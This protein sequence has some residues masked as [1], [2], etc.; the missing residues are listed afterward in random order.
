M[1]VYSL[2]VIMGNSPSSYE[3]KIQGKQKKIYK[4]PVGCVSSL[5]FAA[6]FQAP[7]DLF[8][9]LE[10][11]GMFDGIDQ[12]CIIVIY[13][14]ATK[15]IINK[16]IEANFA[17]RVI[18]EIPMEFIS[19]PVNVTLEDRSI[20]ERNGKYFLIFNNLDIANSVSFDIRRKNKEHLELLAKKN[21]E[22]Y[23]Q[24]LESLSVVTTATNELEEGSIQK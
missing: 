9:D 23:K 14:D 7:A 8:S 1:I 19:C 16:H 12:H 21:T 15:D 5:L 2:L 13:N 17:L 20:E 4:C 11:D 22:K 24:R 6:R 10:I 18:N 3:T